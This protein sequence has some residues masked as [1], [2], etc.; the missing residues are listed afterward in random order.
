MKFKEGVEIQRKIKEKKLLEKIK[1]EQEKMKK[2]LI[3]I[4]EKNKK[5]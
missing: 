3:K 4:Y 5:K 2:V 1:K